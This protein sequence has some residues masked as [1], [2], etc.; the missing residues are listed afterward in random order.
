MMSD[1]DLAIDR[2]RSQD[3]PAC[4]KDAIIAVG[5]TIRYARL[6]CEEYLPNNHTGSDVIAVVQMIL[7]ER[8]RMDEEYM[9][10]AKEELQHQLD[11]M[12]ERE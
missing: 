3:A 11:L 8:K 2:F 5:D 9:A 6:A 10:E 1:F 4:M 7:A 12:A